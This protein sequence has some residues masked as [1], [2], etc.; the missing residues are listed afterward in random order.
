MDPPGNITIL[1]EAVDPG[2]DPSGNITTLHEAVDPGMDSPGNVT[3]LHEAV[4][5]GYTVSCPQGFNHLTPTP[6]YKTE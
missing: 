3:A 6:P 2:M 4:D 1:H 5:P